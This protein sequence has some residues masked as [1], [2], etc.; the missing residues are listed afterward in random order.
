MFQGTVTSTEDGAGV[1]DVCVSN[2][3]EVVQ[4]G[5][6]G[7]FTLDQRPEDRFVFLTVPSGFAS[8]GA[9]YRRVGEDDG[10]DFSLR[11]DPASATSEFSFVQITDIHL[12]VDGTRSI[13]S[14]LEADLAAVVEAVGDTAAFVVVTGDLTNRGTKPE[15]DAFLKGVE[16][17]PLPLRTCIG[18]HD[19]N[20]ANRH[21]YEEALGPAYY[22]FDYGGVHFVAYDG[23]GHEWRDP[24]H[25]EAWLQADLAAVGR[26]T[27]VVV[28]I[29]FPWGDWFYQ[30]FRENNLIATFSGHWH[31]ARVYPDGG[32]VHYN[33]PTFCF[34]GIDQ[35]PRAYR[36][37]TVKDGGLTSEIRALDANCRN[38]SF[39]ESGG[40][41]HIGPAASPIPDEDWPLFRGS[42]SRCGRASADPAPSFSHAWTA[43]SGGGLHQGSPILLGDAIVVGTQNECRPNAAGLTALNAAS[44]DRL[45]H[46]PVASSIKLAPAA[47][48]G[49]VF[50]NTV[51]GEVVALSGSGESLWTYRLRDASER[52]IYSAPLAWRGRV[53]TG[54]SAH[55]VSLDQETGAVDW[56]RDD[57][58]TRDWI[59][60]Y[61]SPAGSGDTLV[62]AFHGQALNLAALDARSGETIWV[63]EEEKVSRTN[64]TPVIGPDGAVYIVSGRTYVRAFD[65]SNGALKWASALD[66]TRCAASPSLSNGNLFVPDGDGGLTALDASSGDVLWSWSS[67][68]GLGSFSP[69]VRGGNGALSSPTT[70]DRFV[71]FGSADGHLHGLDADTGEAVWSHD[72]GVPTLSSPILSGNGLWV[73]SCDGMVHAFSAS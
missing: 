20:D 59:A 48:G 61:P 29:H 73:G 71:F 52:W 12:S 51:T 60:S 49:R 55:F 1:A 22:A 19:D 50:A 30:R 33:T 24:D 10:Y 36:F 40:D 35:S 54:A 31:C 18:N 9:F 26:D 47:D 5:G 38:A 4:T 43:P 8:T 34:G 56:L 13:S 37:N 44:G 23:V 70:T 67:G 65:L 17:L 39:S 42:V 69:Y 46:H 63:L 25:Q 21:R 62:L 32:T 68:P 27:P 45:W 11:P 28:L 53:Y 72:L 16:G 2:G 58:G 15:F 3:R 57:L 14:E 7:R 64:T 6:D 66:A 41:R